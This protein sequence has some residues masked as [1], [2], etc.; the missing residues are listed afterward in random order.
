MRPNLHVNG[1]L[2]CLRYEVTADVEKPT[3]QRLSL[4]VPIQAQNVWGHFTEMLFCESNMKNFI[5]VSN[6]NRFL[7]H[8]S[9]HRLITYLILTTKKR[10][11]ARV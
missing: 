9:Y 11:L 8:S 2:G 3:N 10:V 1:R 5:L 6:S 4:C 7:R